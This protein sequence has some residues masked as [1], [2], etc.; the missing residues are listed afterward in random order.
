MKIAVI[1]AGVSGLS[2]ARFL[3]D[4]CNVTI[5]EKEDR[6][7]GLI[8][9]EEPKGLFHICGGHV[10]NSKRQDV[11]DWF[12]QFFD[13]ENDF[14]RADRNS[15]V[16]FNDQLK[17]PYPIENHV[18]LFD[19]KT[20]RAFINDILEI[21]K[22]EHNNPQ[23]FEDFLRVRFGDTLYRLYFKP[24]NQKVWRRSLR[25]VPLSW[26]EGKLPMPTVE[27]M[28]YNNMNHVEEKQFVH[29][30]FW[31]AK[32]HGSQF[33]ASKLAEGLDI[34]YGKDVGNIHFNGSQW[35]VDGQKFDKVVFC[36][37]IKDMVRSI[38]GVDLSPFHEPVQRLQ[39]HGTTS[40]FCEMDDN[41]YSW[42]YLPRKCHSTPNT[43]PIVSTSILTQYKTKTQRCW[44]AASRKNSVR[45]AF[46]SQADLPTGNTTTWIWQWAQQWIYVNKN[47]YGKEISVVGGL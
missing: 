25:D 38:S 31:Y 47:H 5:F 20:Q 39:Y 3:K 15:V 40:V 21:Y 13:K 44:L 46:I 26:L 28:V 36:G 27:E 1:G 35:I 29:S 41:P 22:N 45:M 7:G 43:L 8:R 19:E 11:L 33:I 12:W 30:T 18:Y 2:A 4:E 34:R 14:V 37:N 10:F 9:C 23:N 42:I 17:V 16:F 32:H 6:P 24:Y